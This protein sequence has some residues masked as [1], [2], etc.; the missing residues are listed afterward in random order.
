[1]I[2]NEVLHTELRGLAVSEFFFFCDAMKLHMVACLMA[3]L[4]FCTPL[5]AAQTEEAEQEAGQPHLL[6]DLESCA[7]TLGS[8]KALRSK[9]SDCS[10]TLRRTIPTMSICCSSGIYVIAAAERMD[11]EGE[12]RG[13]LL[14]EAML[15]L[16]AML[17]NNPDLVRIRLAFAWA[18]FLRERR[19]AVGGAISAGAVEQPARDG[20]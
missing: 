5:S 11:S 2:L 15:A 12:R 16:H 13:T 10:G 14:R 7:L 9:S 8:S 6:S 1:L 20:A 18:L 3:I 4:F 19:R 17:V